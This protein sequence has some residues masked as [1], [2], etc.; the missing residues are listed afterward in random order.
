MTAFLIVLWLVGIM[1]RI[2]RLARFFQIEGYDSRRYLRWLA[3][4]S[5]GS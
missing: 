2:W 3:G 5:T 1:L 4:A